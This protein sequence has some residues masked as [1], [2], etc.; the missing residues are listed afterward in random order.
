VEATLRERRNSVTNRSNE[1]NVDN[2]RASFDESVIISTATDNDM[3]HANSMS[4]NNVGRGTMRVARIVTSPTA[5]TILLCDP[6]GGP[7]WSWPINPDEVD[8]AKP[9]IMI[10]IVK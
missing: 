4:N 2:S 10:P 1:G 7:E 8:L 6:K 5:R 9:V 3:L